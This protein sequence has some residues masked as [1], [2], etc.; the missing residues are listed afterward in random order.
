MGKNHLLQVEPEKSIEH[1]S[2]NY[3][4]A[5]PKH[6][7]DLVMETMKKLNSKAKTLTDGHVYVYTN[8]LKGNEVRLSLKQNPIGDDL[9]LEYNKGKPN[10]RK[11]RKGGN[12]K[13][14]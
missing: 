2:L 12:R 6:K 4:L 7:V 1:L 8:R 3:H 10:F 5:V 9:L 13:P 11:G 14:K